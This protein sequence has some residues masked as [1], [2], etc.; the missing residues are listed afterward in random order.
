MTDDNV[1]RIHPA[2][3]I[4]NPLMNSPWADFTDTDLQHA[5][6]TTRARIAAAEHTLRA[7]EREIARR[8]GTLASRHVVHNHGP[9]EG[10]GLG[11]AEERGPDGLLRGWCVRTP[12]SPNEGNGYGS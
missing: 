12:A 4:P 10:S 8:E 7:V 1:T 9:A 11:C 2:P 5:A 6:L 3:S